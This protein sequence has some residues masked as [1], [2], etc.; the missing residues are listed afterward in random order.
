MKH[1]LIFFITGLVL[2]FSANLALAVFPPSLSFDYL[3]L[4]KDGQKIID[5][6]ITIHEIESNSD[7]TGCDC[8]YPP[9]HIRHWVC[10]A[11]RATKVLEIRK[12]SDPTFVIRIELPIPR[13]R[14]VR[15]DVPASPP[16]S[17]GGGGGILGSD[18][19]FNIDI[20][21]GKVVENKSRYYI[22]KIKKDKNKIAIFGAVVILILGSVVFVR[23][24]RSKNLSKDRL[25]S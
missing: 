20:E 18:R 11:Y 4:Y 3:Y 16:G 22:E 5:N 13:D 2:F 14:K 7:N 25:S 17:M 10:Q 19:Y 1:Y 8:G 24:K 23:K 21:T 15:G 12:T 9:D 6:S